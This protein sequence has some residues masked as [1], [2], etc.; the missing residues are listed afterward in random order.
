[1]TSYLFLM[2]ND[3]KEDKDSLS[4]FFF[5]FSLFLE[6]YQKGF[7]PALAKTISVEIETIIC[8]KSL[9]L[10][11]RCE[12]TGCVKEKVQ[13]PRENCKLLVDPVPRRKVLFSLVKCPVSD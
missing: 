6:G 12:L 8:F 3:L 2:A 1:M 13:N 5:P 10:H 11:Q 4:F 7:S 9:R